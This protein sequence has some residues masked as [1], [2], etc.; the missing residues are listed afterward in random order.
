M[1]LPTVQKALVVP[2]ER[3]PWELRTDFPVPSPG[4]QEV[5]VK[6]MASALNPAD[7]FVQTHGISF[8]KEYPYVGGIDGAGVVEIVGEGVTSLKK[9]D[10]M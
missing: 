6:V 8:V 9:G 10:K 4:P 3:A 1:T 2:T 5:L 7:W